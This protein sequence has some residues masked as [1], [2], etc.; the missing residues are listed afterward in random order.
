MPG[1]SNFA[2]ESAMA[3]RVFRAVRLD[4]I[5]DAPGSILVPIS[6]RALR[7]SSTGQMAPTN[8]YTLDGRHLERSQSDPVV[9]EFT[10]TVEIGE[11]KYSSREART[12]SV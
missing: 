12:L 9:I 3:C 10:K 11:G 1:V 5:E 7:H 6:P 2:L 4:M 8:E